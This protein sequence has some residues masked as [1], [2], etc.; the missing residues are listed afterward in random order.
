[1]QIRWPGRTRGRIN[2]TRINC[3]IDK[4]S[5]VLS[6]GWPTLATVGKLVITLGFGFATLRKLSEL[7]RLSASFSRVLLSGDI[8]KKLSF[9]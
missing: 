1:M 6:F 8:S 4:N 7:K 9:F 3:N 2:W 5:Q